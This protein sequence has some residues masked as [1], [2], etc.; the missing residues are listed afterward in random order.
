MTAASMR[1]FNSK[2][3][4][5]LTTSR[6][7]NIGD[8]ADDGVV[9]SGNALEH[10]PN[11]VGQRVAHHHRVNSPGGGREPECQHPGGTAGRDQSESARWILR[12]CSGDVLLQIG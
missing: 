6:R 4:K 9:G 7:R 3:I 11:A 12:I 1:R 2:L 5:A 10:L 8:L